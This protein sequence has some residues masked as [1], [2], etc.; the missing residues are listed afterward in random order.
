VELTHVELSVATG[1]LAPR[2]EA[3]LD[4][5]LHD[6]FGWVG[7]TTVE[8]VP[9]AG[10]S[11]SRTYTVSSHVKL[12]LREQP[13]APT[14]GT[15][16]HLAFLVEPAELDQ[17]VERTLALANTDDRLELRH[18]RDGRP[19]AVAGGPFVFKTF[20]VRFLLPVWFQFESYE[21]RSDGA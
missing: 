17:L 2:F 8:D 21:S 19:S 12:V 14:A 10:P 20:F 5:M 6:V 1:T 15:D 4:R 18:V 9:D 13:I 11:T 3:D 16:D 7:A